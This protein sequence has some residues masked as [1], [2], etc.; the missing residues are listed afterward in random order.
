VEG[1]AVA[2]ASQWLWSG[3]DAFAVCAELVMGIRVS[4]SVRGG[5]SV[6]AREEMRGVF[7]ARAAAS[8]V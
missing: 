1:H 8:R 6:A 5:R 2:G 4:D 7:G 3:R